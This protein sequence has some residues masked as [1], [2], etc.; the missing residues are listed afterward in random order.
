MKTFVDQTQ[1]IE[2][3]KYRESNEGIIISGGPVVVSNQEGVTAFG[4]II[5]GADIDWNNAKFGDAVNDRK[6][7]EGLKVTEITTT[8]DLLAIIAGLQAQVNNLT[9]LVKGLYTALTTNTTN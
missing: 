8:G 7:S 3:S 2:F 5:N 9:V 6:D 1:Q 4:G